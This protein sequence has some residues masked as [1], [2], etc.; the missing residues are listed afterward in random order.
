MDLMQVW[1]APGQHGLATYSAVIALLLLLSPSIEA[2]DHDDL[3][4]VES[5]HL[6]SEA[7]HPHAAPHLDQEE[8]LGADHCPVCLHSSDTTH[9]GPFLSGPNVD[10]GPTVLLLRPA[11]DSSAART[12]S[13]PRAPPA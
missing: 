12:C 4:A 13:A 11:D 6:H 9:D 7:A 3:H 10:S 5:P 2:F 8:H 1:R